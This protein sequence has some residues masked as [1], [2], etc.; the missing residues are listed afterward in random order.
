MAQIAELVKNGHFSPLT[1]GEFFKKQSFSVIDAGDLTDKILVIKEPPTV[2]L[3]KDYAEIVKADIGMRTKIDWLLRLEI[4]RVLKPSKKVR[5]F[6]EVEPIEI[7]DSIKTT[8]STKK[9]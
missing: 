3:P 7:S 6:C 9:T 8:F 4:E 2:F 5:L 1:I